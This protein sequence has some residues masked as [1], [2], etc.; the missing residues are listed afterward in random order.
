MLGRITERLPDVGDGPR[1][2]VLRD[3]DVGPEPIEQLLLRRDGAVLFD[4]V[5]EDLDQS[6]RELHG[7]A[8]TGKRPRARVDRKRPEADH[9]WTG[10]L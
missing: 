10:E 7:C 9:T 6:R 8:V 4:H 2:G 1:E 3:V 5:G